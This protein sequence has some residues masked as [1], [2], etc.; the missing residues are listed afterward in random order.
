M[1]CQVVHLKKLFLQ[2]KESDDPTV[3]VYVQENLSEMGRQNQARPCL[4]ICP[5]GGYSMCSQREAEPVAL[6]FLTEGFN[7]FVLNYSVAPIRFPIQLWEVAAAFELIQ[8]NA[9]RWHCDPSKLAIMGFSAGGHLAAHYS[10][11]FDRPE[12]REVFP[13]SK[14]V[15]ASV[16]CYPVI[17]ADP[18]VSHKGSFENLLGHAPQSQEETE[19]FSCD[20]Q[21]TQHT[22]PAFLW[23]TAT[24]D[25]VPVM[26]SLLYAHAL[27]ANRVPFELHIYPVGDHGL[28][29]VDAQTNDFLEPCI[30]YAGNWMNA[31]KRWLQL[32]L[33]CE[34]DA[35]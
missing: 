17:S 9:E 12:I 4:L 22:P 2:L 14:P 25:C 13:N 8:D 15:Q 5:G 19:R 34:K 29:T 16:L 26:N 3:T 23:H 21:V 32:I 10:N 20:L 6:N 33:S 31:A 28:S 11:C 7:V 27:A 18:A 30:A 35:E 24:D 1:I